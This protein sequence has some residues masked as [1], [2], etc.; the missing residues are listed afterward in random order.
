LTSTIPSASLIFGRKEKG[1]IQNWI[2]WRF[3]DKNEL[4]AFFRPEIFAN[5]TISQWIVHE[6]PEIAPNGFRLA[7]KLVSSWKI[8]QPHR[9]MGRKIA[10]LERIRK[11]HVSP[12]AYRLWVA[13]ST[14][15]TLKGGDTLALANTGIR[16]N[17]FWDIPHDVME[18]GS[19][20]KEELNEL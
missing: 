16:G 14:Y 11:F 8:R 5:E 12:E 2:K 3:Q 1:I 9:Q 15:G 18:I 10:I 20:A 6:V 17:S 4:F 13:D 7:Y 19:L